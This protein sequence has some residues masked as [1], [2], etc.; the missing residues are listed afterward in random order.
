MQAGKAN[1]LFTAAHVMPPSNQ[2]CRD[3]CSDNFA[4]NSES[5]A[6]HLLTIPILTRLDANFCLPS[7]LSHCPAMQ[8]HELLREVFD[9]KTPKEVS[10][11][12]DLSTSMIYKWAQPRERRRQRHRQSAGPHRGAAPK[13]RRPPARPMALPA[14]RRIFHSQ[15]QEH[16]ASAFPDS[17]H[18]PDRP[19]ICRPAASHRHRRRRQ[20]ITAAESKQIRARW[21]ELK[22]VTEGFVACC[23]EG[24]FGPLKKEAAKR[25]TAK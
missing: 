20:Q 9:K 15:S 16:A 11:D 7:A 17:R 1:Q 24:N 4:R 6:S 3:N 18:Q 25:A 10:A 23:E 2:H 14:R 13:H 5:L 8:S 19:G 22:S 12:L 21:E